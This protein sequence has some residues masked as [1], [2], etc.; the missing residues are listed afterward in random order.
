MDGS[1]DSDEPYDGTLIIQG[2]LS[3][4]DSDYTFDSDGYQDFVIT[5]EADLDV[6]CDSDGT[7]SDQND[8]KKKLHT[9]S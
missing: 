3:D 2:D 6:D 1:K 9:K 7:F 4:D 5:V 8:S